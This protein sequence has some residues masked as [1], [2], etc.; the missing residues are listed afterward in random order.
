MG[1]AGCGKSAVGAALA[2]R[3]DAVYLDGDDLHPPENIAKMRRGEP[4]TDED[5]WP[6]LTL[7]GRTLADPHGTLIL[8]C[9]ALKRRYR[10]HIRKEAGAPVIFVHLAG[11]KQLIT[12]RMAARTGHFMP[13]TLI[14]SQFDALEAPTP[15][16]RPITI[17]INASLEAIVSAI[18]AELEETPA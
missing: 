5:R 14:D 13:T 15:D 10:D 2:A 6:W 1:V 8:G 3:L 11:T 7:V 4:L 18:A 17:D 16:E 12:A 9:S